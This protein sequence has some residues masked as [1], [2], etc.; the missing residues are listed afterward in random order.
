M[1]QSTGEPAPQCALC[2]GMPATATPITAGE[3]TIA[4]ELDMI[5]K[6]EMVASESDAAASTA[7][8]GRRRG[9]LSGMGHRCSSNL[10]PEP[11]SRVGATKLVD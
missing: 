4:Q 1:S 6:A 8:D 11:V 10:S 3:T 2:C 9:G 5:V 7:V